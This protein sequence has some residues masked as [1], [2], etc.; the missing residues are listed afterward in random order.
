[1]YYSLALNKTPR[2]QDHLFVEQ[3]LHTSGGG[4]GALSLPGQIM[5]F[6]GPERM[7][8]LPG[9]PLH[10]RPLRSTKL[11]L[12][13]PL[14]F[15]FGTSRTPDLEDHCSLLI[16]LCNEITYCSRCRRFRFSLG[17]QSGLVCHSCRLHG[18][19]GSQLQ[20]GLKPQTPEEQATT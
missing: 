9:P 1:M 16:P 14:P 12:H 10:P 2:T 6:P 20:V 11:I 17:V 18:V 5:F 4:G 15:Y 3:N 19:C 13:P 7:I 8:P